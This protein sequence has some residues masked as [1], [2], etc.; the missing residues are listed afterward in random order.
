MPGCFS[1][2]SMPFKS[3]IVSPVLS[4]LE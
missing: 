2:L 4:G 1:A 3:V